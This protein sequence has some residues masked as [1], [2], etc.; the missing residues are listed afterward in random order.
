[1]AFILQSLASARAM[2]KEDVIVVRLWSKS[3]FRPPYQR[4]GSRNERRAIESGSEP[5]GKWL[6]FRCGVLAAEPDD[7]TRPGRQSSVKIGTV[8]AR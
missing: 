3:S 7:E 4:Y 6:L 5:F 1:M 8:Q 2:R